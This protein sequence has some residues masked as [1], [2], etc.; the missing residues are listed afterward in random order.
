MVQNGTFVPT[1]LMQGEIELVVYVKYIIMRIIC[2]TMLPWQHQFKIFCICHLQK[3]IDK[4]D[5]Q[6]VCQFSNQRHLHPITYLTRK[7]KVFMK[8]TIVLITDLPRASV[9]GPFRDNICIILHQDAWPNFTML[10]TT[11]TFF[12]SKHSLK[13]R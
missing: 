7:W 12:P 9:I 1:V 2:M 8:H 6:S 5:A 13:V 10:G 11:T 4:V 3:C